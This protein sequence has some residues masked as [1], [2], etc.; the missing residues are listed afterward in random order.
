[1]DGK[2]ESEIIK[3]QAIRNGGSR[4]FLGITDAARFADFTAGLIDGVCFGSGVIARVPFDRPT[5][6]VLKGVVGT[7]QEL[8]LRIIIHGVDN[9]CQV[10]WLKKF[11]L[12]DLEG[13]MLLS[14]LAPHPP[15]LT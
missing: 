1:M 11:P 13:A 7:C 4:V 8:E 14:G 6:A 9:S 2:Q 12:V 5:C 3:L 15:D 10:R